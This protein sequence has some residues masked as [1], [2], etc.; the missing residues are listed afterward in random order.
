[1]SSPLPLFSPTS[2]TSRYSTLLR[3]ATPTV[4]AMLSQSLVSEIDV[5]FFARLPCP[6]SSNGQAALFPSLL[7]LW[8]FGG[9][10]A[11]VGVG[12]QALTARRFAEGNPQFP[13]G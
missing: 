1:M 12:T 3:L 5:L 8:L 9:S 6:E 4:I 13:C 10:L 7:L 11:A 2:S